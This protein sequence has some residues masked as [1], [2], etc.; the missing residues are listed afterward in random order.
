MIFLKMAFSHCFQ[1]GPVK[2]QR[3]I[4]KVHEPG[5]QGVIGDMKRWT[6]VEKDREDLWRGQNNNLEHRRHKAEQEIRGHDKA[7]RQSMK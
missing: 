7:D 1:K 3:G 6:P 5:E 2:G 4:D